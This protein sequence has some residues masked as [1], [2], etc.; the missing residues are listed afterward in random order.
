LIVDCPASRVREGAIEL[1]FRDA[2][3]DLAAH[4]STTAWKAWLLTAASMTLL[5]F[6]AGIRLRARLGFLRRRPSA[7]VLP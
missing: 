5:W 6:V 4:I 7:S 3:S 2:T 1:D